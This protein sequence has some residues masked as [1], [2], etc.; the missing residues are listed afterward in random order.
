V[1]VK[2]LFV[3]LLSNA[4]KFTRQRA[5]AHIEIGCSQINDEV[6]YF[7]KDDGAGFDMTYANRL[8]GVFQRLHRTEDYEGT[9][10]GLAIVK[11]IA[12]RHGGR[13]WADGAV[14]GGATFWF[15]LGS[16]QPNAVDSQSASPDAR[17]KERLDENH[18]ISAREAA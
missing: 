9:G 1:L 14:D 8:F 2:Q 11:R 16:E 4:F 5:V 6:V 12:Q 18:G 13:V 15:T 3:N 17:E 10:V 7:V